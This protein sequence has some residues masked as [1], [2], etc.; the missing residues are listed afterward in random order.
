M[1]LESENREFGPQPL[2]DIL[3]AKGL[4]NH[5]LVAASTEQLT[6]KMVS[7]AVRGR[8]VS[9]R[10]RQKILRALNIATGEVYTLQQLFTY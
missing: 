6:H 2:G 8:F 5:D 3:A 1:E 9:S 7:K 4:Q 10:I